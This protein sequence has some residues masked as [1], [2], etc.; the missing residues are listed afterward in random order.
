MTPL[1]YKLVWGASLVMFTF[2][3]LAFSTLA[4]FYWRQWRQV[5]RGGVFPVFTLLCAVAFLLNLAQQADSR[6]VWLTPVLDLVTGFM[7][8]LLVLLVQQEER[9]GPPRLAPALYVG[10]AVVA[11][12]VI[13]A[14]L[15]LLPGT[16][17][18]RLESLPGAVLGSAAAGALAMQAVSRRRPEGAERR[19]R[20]W[21]RV[22]LALLAASCAASIVLSNPAFTLLPDYL[23]LAIFCV[24]LY[25]KER[26]TFFDL[27]LK[28]GAFFAVGLIAFAVWTA[29][30]A[31]PSLVD[32]ILFVT[33]WLAAPW[34]YRRLAATIDRVWLRRRFTT[35]EA[36]RRF[37]A[38]V[39]VADDEEGLRASAAAALQEIFEAPAGVQFGAGAA[40]PAEL[41]AEIRPHGWM[42][43][44]ARPS[45]NPYLS[46]DRHLLQS[47]ART[48][49]VVLENVRFRE[50]EQELHLLASRA[51][52]KALRAQINPHFLFNALNAIA[53]LIHTNQQA[54]EETVEQLAEVFR[55]TLR[56]SE[57]EWVRL[58]E[59]IEF[60]R[61]YLRIE[62]ARFGPRL[63]VE[64]SIDPTT[65][66]IQIPAMCIQPIA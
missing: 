59:E 25:Y 8:A 54:A 10:S 38:A 11:L 43:L 64:V 16:W 21:M 27:F 60:V 20:S 65:A 26:L 52:L 3:A 53:G 47:L 12:A 32:Q 18:D 45:G 30:L 36:E 23:L 1:A 49:G 61:A 24:T 33:L 51:E 4:L 46:D 37:A 15:S 57:H 28:R 2:G 55:Y 22:L 50:R 14:D 9:V 13:A 31:R 19:Y 63:A 35:A 56:K 48:L 17:G 7:P 58:D 40:P 34:F 6:L 42:T 41:S 66:A 39:Q 5:G 44:G 29:Y 62:Q